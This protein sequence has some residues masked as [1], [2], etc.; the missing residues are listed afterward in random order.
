VPQAPQLC[1][2]EVALTQTPP[3]IVCPEGQ[4]VAPQLPFAHAMPLEQVTPQ[5]PQLE[6]SVALMVQMP[7]QTVP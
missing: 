6:G 7:L 5:L 4:D 2:S 3:Q 1:T